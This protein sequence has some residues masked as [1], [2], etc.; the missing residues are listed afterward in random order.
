MFSV[1]EQACPCIPVQFGASYIYLWAPQVALIRTLPANEG[2]KRDTSSICGSG[3]CPEGKNDSPLQ[4]S[5]LEHPTGRGAWCTTVH[6]VTKQADMTERLNTGES[7]HT[8]PKLQS[9]VMLLGRQALPPAEQLNESRPRMCLRP[10][11]VWTRI[12]GL[13]MLYRCRWAQQG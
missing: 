12:K 4:Y 9:D 8:P 1:R 7:A 2:D 3:R 6:G 5:Y 10:L 11:P 13:N